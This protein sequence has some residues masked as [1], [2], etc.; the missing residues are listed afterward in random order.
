MANV[1]EDLGKAFLPKK[2]RPKIRRYL[3]TAGIYKRPY[4]GTF[5]LTAGAFV[6]TLFLFLVLVLP[7]IQSTQTGASVLASTFFVWLYSFVSFAGIMALIVGSFY[8][9]AKFFVDI[10]IYKR[11]Q[12]MESK[13][14]DFLIVV[15]TNLKGGMNIDAALWNAIKPKFGVLSDEITLVSKKVMTGSE[16]GQALQELHDKY[17][18]PELKRSLSLIISELEVG[19][20]ISKI[21]DDIIAQLKNTEKLKSKMVASVLSYVI[22]ISAI[23]MFITPF[24]FGLS[25]TLIDFIQS[26]IA[27][28]STTLNTGAN[29]PTLLA[30]LDADSLNPENFRTFGYIAVGTIA[31]F[32]SLII[33]IIQ[34]GDLKGGV[35]YVPFY[36]GISVFSFWVSLKVLGFFL[37]GIGI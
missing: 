9:V 11:I 18:S 30:N 37:S 4:T 15:S 16:I 8:L 31:F 13:L 22:F 28:V 19:G 3:E 6:V 7:F 29:A 1:M 10:R 33:S 5:F 32:S 35:K 2:A 26:F 17:D 36:I 21:I 27:R 34:K 20:K 14:P 24:L 25:F 12:E 23:T